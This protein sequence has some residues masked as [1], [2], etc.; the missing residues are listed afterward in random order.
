MN[1]QLKYICK[2][3]ISFQKRIEKCQGDFEVWCMC[4][5]LI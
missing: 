5:Y 4:L 3:V 2:G 1:I